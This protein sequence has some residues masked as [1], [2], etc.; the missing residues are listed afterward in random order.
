MY[1][2][3]TGSVSS[4]YLPRNFSGLRGRSIGSGSRPVDVLAHTRSATAIGR[5]LALED[6]SFNRL[7]Y[8]DYVNWVIDLSENHTWDSVMSYDEE[9]RQLVEL[10]EISWSHRP[11]DIERAILRQKPPV[12][13]TPNTR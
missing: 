1:A 12:I 6:S 5:M 13:N 4:V 10:K 8:T 9:F 2:T 3:T 11:T 7:D